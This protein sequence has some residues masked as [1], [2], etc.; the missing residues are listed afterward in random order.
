M[1]PHVVE[2]PCAPSGAIHQASPHTGPYSGFLRIQCDVCYGSIG[3]LCEDMMAKRSFYGTNGCSI[4][5]EL[6]DRT[7]IDA[8]IFGKSIEVQNVHLKRS[9]NLF[10]HELAVLSCLPYDLS[11]IE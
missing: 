4:P 9:E 11:N 5:F 3:K 10:L 7:I 6:V 1:L 8:L 2:I